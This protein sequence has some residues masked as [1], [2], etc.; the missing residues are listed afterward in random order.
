MDLPVWVTPTFSLLAASRL[1]V[2]VWTR[3]RLLD[4]LLLVFTLVTGLFL[5]LAVAVLID[6]TDASRSLIQALTIGAIGHPVI[7]CV[8]IFYRLIEESVLYWRNKSEF[9]TST[10]GVAVYGAGSRCQLFLRQ[11]SFSHSRNFEGRV[12]AGLIDD[13]TSL[14]NKWVYGY[15]VLGGGIDLPQLIARHRLSAIVIATK[16]TPELMAYV[17]QVA[18]Q[19]GLRL[20]EWHLENRELE[21]QAGANR[22]VPVG[23]KVGVDMPTLRHAKAVSVR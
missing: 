20:S 18:E 21:L 15:L 8:R 7:I 13:D 2:T 22:P 19:F 5:S 3:A 9:N 10:A 1:Y 14:H 23:E 6:P 11:R 12:I 16:L 4:V 17:R